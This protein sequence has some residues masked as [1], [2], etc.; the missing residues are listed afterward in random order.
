MK[1]EGGDGRLEFPQKANRGFE[2]NA[3]SSLTNGWSVLD[4]PGNAPFF[5]ATNRIGTI[6]FPLGTG[7]NSFYRVRVFEP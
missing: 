1:L 2:V 5:S 4:V 6:D 3:S 7:Q